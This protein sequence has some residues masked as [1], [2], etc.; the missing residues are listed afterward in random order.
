MFYI[1]VLKKALQLDPWDLHYLYSKPKTIERL[2][3]ANASALPR[4]G[5]LFRIGVYFGYLLGGLNP[6]HWR[7]QGQ[8]P[9]GA[10]VLFAR[11]KNQRD[12]LN[13]IRA[14]LD[15]AYLVGPHGDYSLGWTMTLAHLF[16]LPFFPYI[17]VLF[18]RST[19]FVREAFHYVFDQYWLI[20][21]FYIAARLWLH[22]LKARALVLSNDHIWE[23]RVMMRAARDEGIPSVYLQ[24][25]S[26]TDEFPPLSMDM[27]LL[28]GY[29]ALNVYEKVGPSQ[30]Q[31]FLLGMPKFDAFA[32]Y[33]N[34]RSGV[35]TI[36]VCCN[37]FDPMERVVQLC[38]TVRSADPAYQLVLRPHPHDNK[39]RSEWLE[40]AR[41]YQAEF[42]DALQENAF[43]FLQNVDVLFSGNS[44]IHLEAALMDVYPI[45]FDYACDARLEKYSFLESGLCEY[46]SDL[47]AVP[48]RLKELAVNRPSVRHRARMYC[49]TVDTNYEG[50]SAE[51][52]GCLIK[53]LVDRGQVDLAAWQR[54][55]VSGLSAYE[56]LRQPAEGGA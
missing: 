9:A 15:G 24:H 2:L 8:V 18:F 4:R 42:S 39:R 10:I 50:R 36:G 55:A 1:D 14:R 20:Y 45:Y 23:C 38:Q 29:D 41:Q 48:N 25:A 54:V 44:N 51:L 47:D 53:E 56:L 17:W 28:H 7:S 43:S 22:R 52:A 46:L 19:G 11:S 6:Q 32:G 13:P 16:S 31:V 35:K 3:L 26:I 49:A 12:G 27:A 21:G 5:L 37:L 30:T 33:R 34:T 40:I